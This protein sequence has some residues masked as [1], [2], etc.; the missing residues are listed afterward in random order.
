MNYLKR[1]DNTWK[2]RQYVKI[3]LG[4]PKNNYEESNMYLES[5]TIIA[6]NS[7]STCELNKVIFTSR[8]EK[9]I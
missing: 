9:E 1:C 2:A 4:F 6:A 8:L 7:S 5:K 3:V